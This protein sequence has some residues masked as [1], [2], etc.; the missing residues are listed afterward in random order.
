MALISSPFPLYTKL[1]AWM[2]SPPEGLS[3]GLALPNV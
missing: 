2:D 3:G 1:Q